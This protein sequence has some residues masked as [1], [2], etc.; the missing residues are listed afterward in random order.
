MQHIPFSVT[1]KWYNGECCILTYQLDELE[2]NGME[3]RN[4]EST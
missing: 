2:Y 3:M 1:N 4:S